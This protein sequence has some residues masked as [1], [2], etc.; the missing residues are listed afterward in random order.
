MWLYSEKEKNQTTSC[1]DDVSEKRH[2]NNKERY[3]N[4]YR[5]WKRLHLEM[6]TTLDFTEF[7]VKFGKEKLA[8]I[9]KKEDLKEKTDVKSHNNI[10]EW[11][12]DNQG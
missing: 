5:Q 7:G 10:L 1:R 12:R 6:Y 9:K 8:K 11:K 4:K 2:A 3:N